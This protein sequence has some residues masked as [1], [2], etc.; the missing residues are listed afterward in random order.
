[1][2]GRLEKS[3]FASIVGDTPAGCTPILNLQLLF[4]LAVNI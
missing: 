3:A 4:T 1:M 2:N